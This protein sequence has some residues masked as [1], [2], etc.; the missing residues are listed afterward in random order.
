MA[1]TVSGDT[2]GRR[3]FLGAFGFGFTREALAAAGLRAGLERFGLFFATAG[4]LG[5]GGFAAAGAA[6]GFVD[7][8]AFFEVVLAL[9]ALLAFM[10]L[11]G[12]G[13]GLGERTAMPLHDR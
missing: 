3:R 6:D 8:F 11:G 5:N 1:S 2:E 10:G 7:L 4:F 13:F 9:M 12:T